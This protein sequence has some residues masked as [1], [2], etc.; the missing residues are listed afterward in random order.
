MGIAQQPNGS[1]LRRRRSTQMGRFGAG[2]HGKAGAKPARL[3]VRVQRLHLPA[4]SRHPLR[5]WANV[6]CNAW[7][8]RQKTRAKTKTIRK[9]EK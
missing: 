7:G 9:N 1:S 3:S 6:G 2:T 8:T 4:S 5:H